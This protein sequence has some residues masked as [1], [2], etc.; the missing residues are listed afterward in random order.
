MKI[1]CPKCGKISDIVH[2]E[3]GRRAECICGAGFTLDDDSVLQDYSFP[4]EPP[5]AQIG[6][7]PVKRYVGSGGMCLVYE[8]IHPELNIPVAI[9]LPKPEYADDRDFCRR[10]AKAACI[11]ADMNHPN[12]VKVY[13][14]GKDPRTKVPYL[15]MEFL[16][17][18]TLFDLQQTHGTFSAEETIQI[19][20]SVCL[21]LIAADKHGIVH[22]D[23]KPDNIMISAD[24]Q[25]KLSD[26]GLAKQEAENKSNHNS[27][28]VFQPD[29]QTLTGQ[30][31]SLGTLE[32]MPPEQ[33]L[34]AA[35]CDSRADI[36]S[37]GVTM[38]QLVTG[39]LP[40]EAADKEMF[41]TLLLMQ[42][43]VVPSDF[44]PELSIDFDYI[45]MTCIQKNRNARYDSPA[46]LLLDLD[47]FLNGQPLPSARLD[48]SGSVLQSSS[49]RIR[50]NVFRTKLF[51]MAAVA[52]V[53]CIICTALLLNHQ[54]KLKRN[55]LAAENA[56]QTQ[57]N[58]GLNS[59]PASGIFNDNESSP[60]EKASLPAV[61]FAAEA[62]ITITSAE[63][64]SANSKSR[65]LFN[66]CVEKA[67][68]AIASGN[69]F[70]LLI[71]ELKGFAKS[72]PDF[73]IEAAKW[74]IQL[75]HARDK[76]IDN[77]ISKLTESVSPA[78]KEG[79]WSEAIKVFQDYN[80]PLKDE[81][82]Q[83]REK[84]I[85][86]FEEAREKVFRETVRTIPLSSSPSTAHP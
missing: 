56:K 34:N 40:I 44:A 47:A 86:E 59:L 51:A 28:K 3:R 8:G 22:R 29:V 71:D 68:N 4:D 49:E 70:D 31:Y 55:R 27:G 69:G 73:E 39:H 53:G 46:E 62:N 10:F 35:S 2:V 9:K 23:I 57:K 1:Q 11:C 32:F 24:G 61:D 36:Y 83:A 7:Y 16:S 65:L 5:P 72:S 13:E 67:Q 26:L 78:L 81:S 25:F 30:M 54:I 20:R 45:V 38:Y 33:L 42:E 79:K 85:Q 18:G 15:V 74:I 76:W 82:R 66:E 52:L 48:I 19:A 6:R 50:D 60:M 80:G 84:K 64:H 12:I 75:E 77:L 43:P 21:G 41:R 63:V 37:L 14:F 17:G 58:E